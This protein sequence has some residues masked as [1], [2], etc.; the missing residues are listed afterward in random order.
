MAACG[1]GCETIQKPKRLK[2]NC[3][4]GPPELR[5]NLGFTRSELSQIK[6]AL[7]LKLAPSCTTWSR[8][9]GHF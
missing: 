1:A 4:D 7:S 2:L 3:P 6:A 5:E 9:H 8:I